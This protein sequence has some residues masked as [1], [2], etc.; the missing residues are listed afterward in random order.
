MP[1]SSN[2]TCSVGARVRWMRLLPDTPHAATSPTLSRVKVVHT[3]TV[4]S[5]LYC[6]SASYCKNQICPQNSHDIHFLASGYALHRAHL[7]YAAS[8]WAGRVLVL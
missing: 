3:V 7:S 2:E 1:S 6:T 5:V 4:R 8:S